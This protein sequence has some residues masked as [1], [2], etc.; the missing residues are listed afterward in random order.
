MSNRKTSAR[1]TIIIIMI[2]VM[3]RTNRMMMINDGCDKN[4]SSVLFLLVICLIFVFLNFVHSIFILLR[5]FQYF[6][7]VCTFPCPIFLLAFF[8]F[9][10]FLFFCSPFLVCVHFI[11]FLFS[12][13]FLSFYS[14]AVHFLC[15][16]VAACEGC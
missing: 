14:F 11:S 3:M 13:V 9:S 10:F 6:S 12:A 2:V 8:S 5:V 15:V 4:M 1:M 16:C 7:P